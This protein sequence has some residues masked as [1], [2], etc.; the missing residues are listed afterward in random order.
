MTRA[1]FVTQER[2]A[3]DR[4]MR[5]FITA[6]YAVPAGSMGYS[7]EY[8]CPCGFITPDAGAIW[9]HRCEKVKR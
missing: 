1:E 4:F 9:D 2:A 3:K 5:S 7:T 6:D 8:R